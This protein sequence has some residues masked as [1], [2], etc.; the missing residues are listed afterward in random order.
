MCTNAEINDYVNDHDPDTVHMSLEEFAQRRKHGAD[1]GNVI[2]CT[3]AETPSRA[4]QE[5][6][7]YP[8]PHVPSCQAATPCCSTQVLA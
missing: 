7:D 2:T 3:T 5:H 6:S 8:R 4:C 1:G